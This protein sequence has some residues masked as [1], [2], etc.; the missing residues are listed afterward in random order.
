MN[1]GSSVSFLTSPP[2]AFHLAVK[3]SALVTVLCSSLTVLGLSR[4]AMRFFKEALPAFRLAIVGWSLST[5]PSTFL[6]STLPSL[7]KVV[8]STAALS[9]L[10]VRTVNLSI[11]FS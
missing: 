6:T 4:A 3:T 5:L 9:I 11:N 2:T 7:R 8:A 1:W 10:P